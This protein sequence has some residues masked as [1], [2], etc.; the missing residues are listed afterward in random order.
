MKKIMKKMMVMLLSLV[1]VTFMLTGCKSS[2]EEK[3]PTDEPADTVSATPTEEAKAVDKEIKVGIAYE[4]DTLDPAQANVDVDFM[5]MYLAGE[6]LIRSAE[7]KAVPGSAESWEANEENTEY[8]FHL[9]KDSTFSDGTPITAEDFKYSLL[10]TLDPEKA[11]ANTSKLSFITNADKYAA[12]E[13]AAEDVGIEVIDEYTLKIT[14]AVATYPISFSSVAFLP[15]K[16]DFVEAAGEQ[17][18]TEADKV[19]T[20]GAFAITDWVHDSQVTLV[21]NETYW[22]AASIN[23]TKIDGMINAAGDT[24][25][26]MM[27][28]G[29]LDAVEFD[30]A[31][32]VGTLSDAGYSTESYVN[33]YQFLN[34]SYK[35]ATEET[36][37]WLSNK[38]FRLALSNALDRTALVQSVY[39]A[40]IPASRLTGATEVGADQYFN[41]EHPYTGWNV[42]QDTAKAQEY[43]KLAMAEMGVSS[44]EEIPTFTMLCFDSSNNMDALNAV[45]DMWLKT[46]GIKC[47][48]D[49]Q[50]ISTMV[51]KAMAGE[52]DFWKGGQA[53]SSLDWLEFLQ[54][55]TS[56][57]NQVYFYKDAE[58]DKLYN[59]ANTAATWE[60]RK[61]AMFELEKYFCENVVDL[62]VTWSQ[63]TLVFNDRVTGTTINTD[64]IDYTYA[65]VTE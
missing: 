37:K 30:S 34:I 25:V 35:G 28:A 43:M 13:A 38:N 20:N 41:E 53:V 32:P 3:T 55:F 7:G 23:L 54:S 62:Q 44:V 31:E 52:F 40:D 12:G 47:Q 57:A 56:E 61:D 10:R 2:S 36:G 65:D 59:A 27:L 26:D 11:Y 33:G 21:K 5:V 18:G 49:A 46:L 16:Q 1:L 51:S 50:P 42:T 29:D 14:C 64:A 19:L 63:S 45:A 6:A 4:M 8:T 60:E 48:I 24:A 15:L 9:R 22:N 17:Y 58:F 39:T